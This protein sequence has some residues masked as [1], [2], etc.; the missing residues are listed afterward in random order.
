MMINVTL[1]PKYILNAIAQNIGWD[2][3]GEIPQE[4]L[5]E[6]AAMS[7]EY[8]TQCYTAWHLGSRQWGSTII[9]VID[10]LREAKVTA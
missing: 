9:D 5:D 8:A 10:T 1:A 6:I 3:K 2:G 4:Y 7:P